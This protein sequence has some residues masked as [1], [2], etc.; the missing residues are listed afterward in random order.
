MTISLFNFLGGRASIN[1]LESMRPSTVVDCSRLAFNTVSQRLVSQSTY[2]FKGSR[3]YTFFNNRIEAQK[4]I[5]TIYGK[6]V[7]IFHRFSVL[8]IGTGDGMF[9]L[10]LPQGVEGYGITAQD[11]RCSASLVDHCYRV[12]NAEELTRIFPSQKFDL[13]VSHLAFRH[14]IDPLEAVKQAYAALKPKGILLIDGFSLHGID[15][16]EWL[17]ILHDNGYEATATASID[18]TTS[19]VSQLHFFALRKTKPTFDDHIVYANQPLVK[20]E[21]QF[22]R[23]FYCFRNHFS[24]ST[25]LDFPQ[26]FAGYL[27]G[28][29]S[30]VKRFENDE[31][32]GAFKGL[33]SAVLDRVKTVLLAEDRRVRTMSAEAEVRLKE[34]EVLDSEPGKNKSQ[35]LVGQIRQATG[36]SFCGLMVQSLIAATAAIV[37]ATTAAAYL[38]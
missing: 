25:V 13:I 27:R 29:G 23:A 24:R 12:G 35:L 7:G 34:W 31:K 33:D 32:E 16:E 30:F 6:N 4:V 22:P 2:V 5:R 37:I 28:D 20:D 11:F 3:D 17:K 38:L 8:D 18:K 9:L 19:I 10:Q 15:V 14:F 36:R 21:H 26:A 1:Q